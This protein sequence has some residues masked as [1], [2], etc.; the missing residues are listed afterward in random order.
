MCVIQV[1]T[2]LYGSLCGLYI[3]EAIGLCRETNSSCTDVVV[4]MLK[5]VL[6]Y[7]YLYLS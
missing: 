2:L 4:D 5:Q 1:S 7:F 6:P 3:S